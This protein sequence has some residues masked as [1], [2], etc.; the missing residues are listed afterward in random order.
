M[1]KQ[2]LAVTCFIFLSPLTS[3]FSD[4]PVN[5]SKTDTYADS[6]HTYEAKRNSIAKQRGVPSLTKETAIN[7]SLVNVEVPKQD[8][9]MAESK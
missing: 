1:K 9:P 7:T 6:I 8:S 3:A 4:E 2:L 5:A